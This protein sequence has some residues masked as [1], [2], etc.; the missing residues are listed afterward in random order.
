MKINPNLK[1][2]YG[3]SVAPWKRNPITGKINRMEITDRQEQLL[4]QKLV[5]LE[6]LIENTKKIN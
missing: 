5:A 1:L 6:I 3:D 4:F 2:P